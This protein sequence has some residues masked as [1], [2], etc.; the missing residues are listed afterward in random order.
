VRASPDLA[1]RL[2]RL[3]AGG[4]PIPLAHFMALANAH[5][6]ATRDPL[7]AAGDFT[8]APEISQM[9]GEL[10]GLWAAD[11]WL[12]A[13]KPNVAWV[14]LGPGR[15]TLSADA[16]RAV[17]KV[18][19][20][21]PVH[22]VETSP[23]LRRAQATAVRVATHHDS[24]DTLP[25]DRPLIVVANEFFDALP[26]RQIVRTEA[27]WRERMVDC[28]GDRL[29]PTVGGQRFDTVVPDTLREGEVIE[30]SPASVSI[31]RDLAARI[32][33]QSGALL[34]I[35][36]GYEGPLAGDTLQALRRHRFADPFEAP[37]EQDLTAHVDFAALAEA[38]RAED[39]VVH[40]VKTQGDLLEALGIAARATSLARAAPARQGEIETAWRRLCAPDEMGTLFKALAVT[41]PGWP[42]PGGFG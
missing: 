35:D 24:I 25:T 8:T 26:I 32:V 33:A 13:G 4:G 34:A 42:V 1:E 6:Y 37:G 10:I 23:V 11:L 17:A 19:L 30:T 7:G 38:A 22:L 29:V 12:R 27:G 16:L 41:A 36:Y 18:G 5:Y 2:H 9:F 14:E 28:D 21:P 40:K 3:I 39:A 15:G 31:L 20:A